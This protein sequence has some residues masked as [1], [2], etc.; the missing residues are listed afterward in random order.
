[1][2]IAINWGMKRFFILLLLCAFA[3]SCA[4]V[5]SGRERDK[6]SNVPFKTVLKEP[7]KYKG[8]TFIW[9]GTIIQTTQVKTGG[10]LM[11]VLENPLSGTGKVKN[12]N[13]SDGRFLVYNAQ[14][15]DPVIYRPGRLVA[16]A[17]E[18]VEARMGKLGEADYLF[19]VLRANEIH[20][21]KEPAESNLHFYPS[22]FMG[23]GVGR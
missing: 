17:G 13:H 15:L 16:V 4:H 18:L 22:I 21:L 8:Q 5:V 7:E 10:S 9:G 12:R 3:S 19:P 14:M 20:L 2:K 11:E 1:M 6:A 23:V